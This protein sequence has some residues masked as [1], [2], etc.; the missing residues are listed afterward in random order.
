MQA[1]IFNLDAQTIGLVASL[2]A[3]ALSA[4]TRAALAD[5]RV[6]LIREQEQRCAQCA[7]DRF[8]GRGEFNQ[9]NARVTHLEGA[10]H[11]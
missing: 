6:Q 1:H 10:P 7:I 9:L 2:A 11:G 5:L 8:A 4:W 3:A